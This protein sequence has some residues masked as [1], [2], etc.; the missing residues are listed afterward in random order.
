[1]VIYNDTMSITSHDIEALTVV[2][3]RNEVIVALLIWWLNMAEMIHHFCITLCICFV[4]GGLTLH[5]RHVAPRSYTLNFERKRAHLRAMVR[6]TDVT[7]YNQIRMYRTTFD[8]LCL[9]LDNVGGLKP[10][11]HM[12]V[13]EQVTMFLHI[14]AHHMKNSHSV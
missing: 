6:S 13:D 12:L 3:M 10:M 14:L 5:R 1:M 4:L 8:K 11:K 9:L 7:C 2:A